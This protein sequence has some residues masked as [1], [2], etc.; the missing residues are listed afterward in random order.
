M[1]LFGSQFVRILKEKADQEAVRQSMSGKGGARC[2]AGPPTVKVWPVEWYGQAW[3][4]CV[5][6]CLDLSRR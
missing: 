3:W 1:E 4:W 5:S 6:V 2:T